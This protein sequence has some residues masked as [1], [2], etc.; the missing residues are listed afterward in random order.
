MKNKSP[1]DLLQREG[2]GNINY[3]EPLGGLPGV[4]PPPP[5]L[6]GAN[7]GLSVSS[8]NP[9][10]VVL[11]QNVGQAGNPAQ[12]ISNR[13]IPMNGMT[14]TFR[15]VG[16]GSIIIK[17]SAGTTLTTPQ[18]LWQDS[19]GNEVGRINMQ[20]QL[21]LIGKLAGAAIT[22][23]RQTV[24]GY[25]ALPV[26]AAGDQNVII[27]DFSS[28]FATA[29]RGDTVVGS[30][31][32]HRFYTGGAATFNTAIGLSAL[33]SIVNGVQNTCVGGGAGEG[34]QLNSSNNTCVGFLSLAAGGAAAQNNNTV[35]GAR[36]ANAGTIVNNNTLIGFGF[37]QA[38]NT[39][40]DSII[41]LGANVTSSNAGASSWS[42]TTVIGNGLDFELSN[43]VLLGRSDQNVIVGATPAVSPT[44]TGYKLQ[45][46]GNTQTRHLV[47]GG[48]APAA[49]PGAGITSTTLTGF[50]LA[51]NIDILTGGAGIAADTV[52]C[53]VTHNVAY[54]LNPFPMLTPANSA[55]AAINFYVIRTGVASFQILNKVALVATTH[56]ILDY[57][58][59][60]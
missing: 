45:V 9:Q 54:T 32:I 40:I 1:I 16:N 35:I 6:I 43:A 27:G 26:Q 18:V 36:L 19:L 30:A 57:V 55:A 25:N 60:G 39:T 13:E 50:D 37:V 33:D 12:L 7:N 56:Y 47:G 2:V 10:I 14:L 42:N 20:A 38:A 24:I 5:T 53:T 8:I 15:D 28:Q 29:S 4:T 46:L 52:V 23:N 21:V 44:D 58:I 49:A 51:G 48:T 22:T 31:A 59:N 41:I 34:L 17:E 11:G 3:S